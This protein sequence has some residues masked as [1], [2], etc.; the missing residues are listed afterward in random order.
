MSGFDEQ[1]FH[2]AGTIGCGRHHGEPLTAQQIR[3]LPDGA[4]IV[5]TWSGGNG[6]W[7]YRVL[8][9]V[10]GSL[11]VENLYPDELLP[12][13][14]GSHRQAK[15]LCRVTTGW[16]EETRSWHDRKVA[17]PAHIRAEW[18]R[19]RGLSPSATI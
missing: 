5:V 11:R 13:D 18:A 6:P 15:P 8:V 1:G 14:S 19:L 12:Y 16:D 4:E 7:P 3:E 9:D 10:A 17:E 2:K